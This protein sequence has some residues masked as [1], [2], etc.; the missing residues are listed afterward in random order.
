M[1]IIKIKTTEDLPIE[2]GK[3][4]DTK[5]RQGSFLV[6]KI[7]LDKKGNQSI[8]WGTYLKSNLTNCPI[9]VDRLI[10]GKKTTGEKEVCDRCGLNKDE[11]NI[12]KKHINL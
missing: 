7:S 12:D 3:S 5:N 9:G 2:V 6:N 10:V 1:A 4:Y 8:A 11:K